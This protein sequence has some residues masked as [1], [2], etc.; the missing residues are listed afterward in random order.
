MIVPRDLGFNESWS[1]GLKILPGSINLRG[2][3]KVLTVPPP[4]WSAP[5]FAADREARR[6]ACGQERAL[7]RRTAIPV[8]ETRTS[9]TA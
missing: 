8:K 6:E 3:T 2:V 4:G 7:E 9:L 5:G 1:R